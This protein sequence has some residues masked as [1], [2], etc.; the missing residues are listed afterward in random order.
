M[1]CQQCGTQIEDGLA[2]CTTC[3][4]KQVAATTTNN[5]VVN[6]GDR[7]R[8]KRIISMFSLLNNLIIL[9]IRAMH[10]KD[11]LNLIHTHIT[12]KRPLVRLKE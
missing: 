1:F 3:G 11:M 9:R 2:F 12:M 8:T 10:L 4:A 5:T 6:N 7:H